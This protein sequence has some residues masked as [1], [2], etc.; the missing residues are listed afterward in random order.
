MKRWLVLM[1]L[2]AWGW[3]QPA[4]AEPGIGGGT[5][6]GLLQES[7]W[8]GREPGAPRCYAELRRVHYLDRLGRPRVRSVARRVCR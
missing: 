5:S 6:A 4:F 2:A 3:A 8:R 7:P 1:V